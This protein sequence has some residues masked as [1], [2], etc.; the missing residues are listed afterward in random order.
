M[1][2]C[3]AAFGVYRM[4]LFYQRTNQNDLGVANLRQEHDLH[5]CGAARK[6][7][8]LASVRGNGIGT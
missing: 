6:I 7:S 8:H 5:R 3:L 4:F 1:P 2:T